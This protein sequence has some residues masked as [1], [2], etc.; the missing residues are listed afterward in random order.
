M[1]KAE[2]RLWSRLRKPGPDGM[3]FRRQ[4][5]IGPCIVDFFCPERRLVVEVDG[6]QHGLPGAAMRDAERDAWLADRGYRVIRFTNREVM[7]N[8]DG[9]CL[10]IVDWSSKR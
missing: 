3:R 8:I 1:T 4:A 5:P 6:D 10:T 7:T 2:L 9:V